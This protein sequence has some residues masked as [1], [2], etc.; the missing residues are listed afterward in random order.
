MDKRCPKCRLVNPAEAE[1]CDCGWDFVLGR[2]ESSY[3]RRKPVAA[4][5]GVGGGVL[6][7]LV[8]IK[9]MILFLKAKGG[10]H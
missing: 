3:L 7:L 4:A 8:V 9:V 2:Q 10:P 1:R 6:V 5:V